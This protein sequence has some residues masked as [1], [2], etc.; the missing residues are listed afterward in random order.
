MVVAD[1]AQELQHLRLDRHVERGGRL[2]GDQQ[3]RLER[4]A[5]G[6]HRP[7]LHAA[8]ELVRIF[9][10]ALLRLAQMDAREQL[11]RA[12]PRR[13]PCAPRWIT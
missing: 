11:D 2:V 5:H 8:R 6:D 10:R 9:A 3:L 7:L 13:R 1:L 4:Q 12:G